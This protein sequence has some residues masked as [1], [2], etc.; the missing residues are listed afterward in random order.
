MTDDNEIAAELRDGALIASGE[1]LR[2]GCQ[3]CGIAANLANTAADMIER[4]AAQ[5]ARLKAGGWRP[6]ATAPVDETV[7]L[8]TTGEWVGT[9][10]L[11]IDE[12]TGA[13]V[14]FWGTNHPVHPRHK[15]LG[16]QPLPPPPTDTPE[17]ASVT[18]HDSMGD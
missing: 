9:A 1:S 18:T 13:Y 6:I 4:Q 16:W 2:R 15:P 8:A 14:W 10:E 11:H 3:N 17:D 5:I 12:D 7:L